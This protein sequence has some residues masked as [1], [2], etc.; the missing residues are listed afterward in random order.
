MQKCVTDGAHLVE[1]P[2]YL[3]LLNDMCMHISFDLRPHTRTSDACDGC[4]RHIVGDVYCC[5]LMTLFL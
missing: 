3:F 5:M 1:P 4:V 2:S